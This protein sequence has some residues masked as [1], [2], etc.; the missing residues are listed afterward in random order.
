ML[1]EHEFSQTSTSVYIKLDRNLENMFSISFT[2]YR[3]A[4][5]KI[6]LFTLIT[7]TARVSSVSIE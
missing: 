2:K 5:K 7:S 4:K 6:N 1:W 3:D